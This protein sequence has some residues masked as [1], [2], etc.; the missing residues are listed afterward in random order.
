MILKKKISR[1]YRRLPSRIDISDENINTHKLLWA[2]IGSK[3]DTRRYR[4]YASI[5]RIDDPRYIS[6]YDYYARVEPVLNNRS[7]SEA[8]SDK[9]LYHK[10]IDNNFLPRVF[11]RRIH[12]Q[13]YSEN[14]E[15]INS[16]ENPDIYIPAMY[17]KVL[18]KKAIDSGG[19]RDVVLFS[20]SSEVWKASDGTLLNINYLKESS[21]RNF[22][23]QEYIEQHPFFQQFNPYSVNTVRLYTYRSVK[24]NEIIPIQA[25]L[26]IGRP[27]SIVDNMASGGVACGITPQ[28]ILNNFGVN[29]KA[30]KLSSFNGVEFSGIGSVYNFNMIVSAGIKI[31]ADYYYQ[32]IL[33]FDFCIDRE[34]AVK[35]IEINNRN[36]EINFFQMNN[37]PLFRDYTE[38]IVEYCMT[39]PRN[40]L[41]DFEY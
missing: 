13:F 1:I 19:G 28:G 8:F 5:S 25:V 32:R 15:V 23:I 27:G 39:N 2:K 16:L 22:I 4:S 31:A 26:R 21:A 24:T 14:Y 11:L 36:N 37:G 29:K 35:L 38:E 10:Y 33:G 20:R 34:G 7:F 40:F 17:N 41:I 30:E 6:E 18:L 12:N 3:P 9:N